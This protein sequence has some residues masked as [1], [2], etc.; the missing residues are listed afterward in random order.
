[1]VPTVRVFLRLQLQLSGIVRQRQGW[2]VLK[3]FMQFVEGLHLDWLSTGDF[4]SS[5]LGHLCVTGVAHNAQGMVPTTMGCVFPHQLAQLR[6]SP[7]VMPMD[8]LTA[9]IPPLRLFHF[10]WARTVCHTTSPPL[11]KNK[12]S[13]VDLG[14]DGMCKC[15][16]MYD[17]LMIIFRENIIRGNTF[18]STYQA[19]SLPSLVH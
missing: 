3:F 11:L 17:V 9:Y 7:T 13:T 8:Q 15:F 16:L 14:M 4:W 5:A 6:H 2:R 18:I 19:F 12:N 1:M 10:Q